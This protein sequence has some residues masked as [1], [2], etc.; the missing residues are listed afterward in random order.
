LQ[1]AVFGPGARYGWQDTVRHATG[2]RLNPD[3]FVRSLC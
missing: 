1:E 2:E 3:Y